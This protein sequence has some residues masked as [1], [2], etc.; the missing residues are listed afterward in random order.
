MKARSSPRAQ[1]AAHAAPKHA[2][3]QKKLYLVSKCTRRVPKEY[4]LCTFFDS[5][6]T[7]RG[8]SGPHTNPEA[9]QKP[10]FF[11]Q[12]KTWDVRIA[13]KHECANS[14]DRSPQAGRHSRKPARNR[15]P[16]R[17]QPYFARPL[18]AFSPGNRFSAE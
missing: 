12:G 8:F 13:P 10:A 17:I 7:L 4:T 2:H 5:N 9:G 3:L 18:S 11:F 1:A 6:E 16:P 15:I 14:D